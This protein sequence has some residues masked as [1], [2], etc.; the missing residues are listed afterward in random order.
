MRHLPDVDIHDEI[1]EIRTYLASEVAAGNCLGR[2]LAEAHLE[3]LEGEMVRRYEVE[4][5][6]AQK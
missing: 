3:T 1:V 2:K 5:W 4:M 6:G